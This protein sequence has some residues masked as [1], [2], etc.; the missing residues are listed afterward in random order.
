MSFVAKYI[1]VLEKL[2][3]DIQALQYQGSTAF[4][5]VITGRKKAPRQYP[6]CMIEPEIIPMDPS[7]VNLTERQMVFTIRVVGKKA[8][9][10]EGFEEALELLQLV[11][12]ML[13]N[14]RSFGDTVDRLEVYQWE[15]EVDKPRVL[16]RHECTLRVTFYEIM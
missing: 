12:E 16:E 8:D 13:E 5:E 6:S 2:E 9:V 15:P 3:T 4:D 10:R 11:H 14:D 1:E 7:T